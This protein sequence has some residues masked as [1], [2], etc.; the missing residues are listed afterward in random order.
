MPA[1]TLGVVLF[2]G[3]LGGLT[4]PVASFV[5]VVLTPLPLWLVN[6]VSLLVY[7]AVLPFVAVALTFLYWDLVARFGRRAA[8]AAKATRD[9]S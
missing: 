2:F 9:S 3:A 5:L 7:A 6:V 4:A 1:R 8:E